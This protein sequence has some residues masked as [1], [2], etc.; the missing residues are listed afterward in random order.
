MGQMDHAESGSVYIVRTYRFV[1][2]DQE[3]LAFYR[4]ALTQ[5][6]WHD[7]GGEFQLGDAYRKSV[8]GKQ[9]SFFVVPGGATL[10]A[11]PSKFEVQTG[12]NYDL[13][14]LGG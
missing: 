7:D 11:D 6:G 12:I 2:G 14:L 5:Q 4:N 9:A 3:L 10:P 13:G 8:A 1:G